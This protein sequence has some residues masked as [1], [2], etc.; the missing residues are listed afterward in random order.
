MIIIRFD[1]DH[2][3]IYQNTK[4]YNYYYLFAISWGYKRIFSILQN[5]I[6][7]NLIFL[8]KVS[9]DNEMHSFILSSILL[10]L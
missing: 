6:Y 4:H 2:L 5:R 9:F 3:A 7:I 8:E 1:H 10:I